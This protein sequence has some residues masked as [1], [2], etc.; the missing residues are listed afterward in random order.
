M[1][2][3]NQNV[4]GNEMSRKWKISTN[5]CGLLRKSELYVTHESDDVD[6][7]FNIEKKIITEQKIATFLTMHQMLGVF[8]EKNF[9]IP[10]CL[11]YRESQF[12]SLSR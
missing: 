10:K 8:N 5:F 12:I 2:L 7:H 6:Q 9:G 3:T 4:F 1:K 11:Y